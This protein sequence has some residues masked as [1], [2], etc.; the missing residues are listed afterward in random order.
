MNKK[1]GIVL[2]VVGALLLLCCLGAIFFTKGVAEKVTETINRDHSFVEKALNATAKTW[3]EEEFSKYAEASFNTPA[4]REETRKL[5]ATLKKNLGA[6]TSLEK[7]VEEKKSFKADSSSADP[8]FLVTLTAK[9]KFEKGGGVFT[10]TVKNYKAQ[11]KITDIHLDP[12]P[13]SNIP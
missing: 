7:P 4:R 6:M 10:V 5:F 1:V 8:G 3:D 13:G 11:T 12:L 2:A 9:A